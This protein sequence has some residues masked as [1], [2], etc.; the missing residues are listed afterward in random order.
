MASVEDI[1]QLKEA[2]RV[3]KLYLKHVTN[4]EGELLANVH[5]NLAFQE[6]YDYRGTEKM[7]SRLDRKKD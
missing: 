2:E 6:V 1:A 4:K 5:E 3:A 7:R